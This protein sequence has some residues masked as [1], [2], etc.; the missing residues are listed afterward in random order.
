[1]EASVD[2]GDI[3]EIYSFA[4]ASGS[5]NLTS[6][7]EDIVY[8]S[9]T[10][11]ATPGLSR[12]NVYVSPLTQHREI[13]VVL[14]R[15]HAIVLAMIPFQPRTA[16]VVITRIHS[17]ATSSSDDRRRIW[18]GEIAGIDI[19]HKDANLRIPGALDVAF[20]IDV[21]IL[22]VQKTC[23]HQLYSTGCGTARS[24]SAVK[25]TTIAS[26]NGV[27]ISVASLS[28]WGDQIARGGEIL[29]VS[30]SERRTILDQVGSDLIIDVPFP[31]LA[32]SDSV[33]VTKGCDK[34]VDVCRGEFANIRNFAGHP[35]VPLRNPG[36]PTGRGVA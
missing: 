19:G 2:D 14:P 1:M 9:I 26:V 32:V 4:I 8:N 33:E 15:N 36:S 34:S 7:L 18:F 23:Q 11:T 31:T 12:G 29:R 5:Y 16:N 20:D 17:N 10:Y 3:R 28:G 25:T 35:L 21:P 6:H 30:D 27:A 22:R 24:G 13:E